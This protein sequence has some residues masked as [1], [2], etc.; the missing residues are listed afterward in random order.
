MFLCVH[1]PVVGLYV[2]VAGVLI[3]IVSPVGSLSVICTPVA[4][5]GPLLV[6][7]M[8]YVTYCVVVL[9]VCFC[10]WFTCMS[11]AGGTVY[12]VVCLLLVVVVCRIGLR[13]LGLL[14]W[15]GLVCC[16][17]IAITS[18]EYFHECYSSCW[19][20]FRCSMLVCSC[21]CC[22]LLFL[23]LAVLDPMYFSPFPMIYSTITPVASSVPVSFIHLHT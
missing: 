9:C 12:A 14:L 6:A 3:C 19:A 8:V 13:V 21:C 11:A 4:L 20:C 10:V 18:D 2:P 1:I 15:L 23:L 17:L 22:R 7:V 5:S 16:F